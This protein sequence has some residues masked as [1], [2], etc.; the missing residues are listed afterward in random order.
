MRGTDC[1]GMQ[2]VNI[3]ITEKLSVM[4]VSFSYCI[5][6]IQDRVQIIKERVSI[7]SR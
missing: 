7:I 2:E 1:K 5:A 4:I 3:Y 6:K